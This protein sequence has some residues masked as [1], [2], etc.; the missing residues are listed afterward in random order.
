LHCLGDYGIKIDSELSLDEWKKIIN[1]LVENNVFYVNISGGEPTQN[2]NFIE[3]INYLSSKGLHF[4]ITTNGLI[5]NKIKNAI[6]DNREYLIGVKISLD[7]YNAKSHCFL[8]RD[9]NH[10]YNKKIFRTT[11]NTIYFFKKREIPLTIATMIHSNNIKNFDKFI[12]L[13]KD[14]NPISWFISPIVPSG[15]G[16]HAKSI[17][18]DYFYYSPIF[19]KTIVNKCNNKKINV[20]LVDLPFSLNGKNEFNYFECGAALSFCEIHSDG[21]VSPCTLCRT[22][23]PKEFIVFDNIKEKSLS[24]IW[25]GK[26]FNNFRY[27]MTK[28]CEGCVAFS[29]CNKCI[30]Q[31][32]MYFKNGYSP[33]PYCIENGEKLGLK[34]LDK[35]KIQLSKNGVDI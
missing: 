2:P 5:S 4:I 17:K 23:I 13:I 12:S 10:K 14:I 30:A 24:D 11:L 31:S 33:T 8:R 9:K 7:G 18:K 20:R 35:F 32:F 21:T 15:R 28:G 29:K 22:S 1:E 27:Y 3:I 26:K 34:N 6:V 16:K 25:N 19:W